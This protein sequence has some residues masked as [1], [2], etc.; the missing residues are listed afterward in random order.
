MRKQKVS[1]CVG[2]EKASSSSQMSMPRE[3]PARQPGAARAPWAKGW[4]RQAGKSK[5]GRVMGRKRPRWKTGSREEKPFK[6]A[7]LNMGLF[8]KEQGRNKDDLA[9]TKAL[10]EGTERDL[11][12][13]AE[14]SRR[15]VGQQSLQPPQEHSFGLSTEAE[16]PGSSHTCVWPPSETWKQKLLLQLRVPPHHIG[17]SGQEQGSIH[18]TQRIPPDTH[19]GYTQH[20]AAAFKFNF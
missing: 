6:D 20:Y 4:D 16:I 3:S 9:W 13:Q 8:A 18:G 19:M 15:E 12:A 14:Q 7:R 1:G 10:R 2:W 17:S 11:T 5:P